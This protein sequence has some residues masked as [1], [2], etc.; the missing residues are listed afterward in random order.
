MSF[1]AIAF[2]V[3]LCLVLVLNGI[4]GAAAGAR[5]QFAENAGPSHGAMDPPAG[6][7]T[8]HGDASLHGA[9]P[10]GHGDKGPA[11]HAKMPVPD[12]CKGSQCNCACLSTALVVPATLVLPTV[13]WTGWPGPSHGL[14][15]YPDPVPRNQ[16][17]PPIC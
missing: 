9:H 8:C 14:A 17:R 3:L 16:I 7:Q 13:H 12:C 2:R 1:P 6:Q 15:G 4:G 5:M 11:D 10:Y